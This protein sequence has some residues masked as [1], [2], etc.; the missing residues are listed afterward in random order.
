[1]KITITTVGSRG[2]VQPYVALGRGLVAAGH[3]VTLAADPLF[4]ATKPN[5]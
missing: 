4:A 3:E 1:M 2:D 5:S